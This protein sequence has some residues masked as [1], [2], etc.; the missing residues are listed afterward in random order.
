MLLKNLIKNLKQAKIVGNPDVDI[1]DIVINSKKT[2]KS[3]L[4]F[5][6]KGR[7][8]NGT[9]FVK[10]AISGGAVAIVTEKEI[11][12][13][14][15]QI[16]VQDCRKALSVVCSNFY[17]NPE[18]KMK[19]IAIIGTNG[20]TTT[21]HYVY[22]ILKNADYKV[23]L[24]GTLGVK[25]LDKYIE[26]DLT[27]P[28]PC[29]FYYL[30]SKMACEGITHLVMELSAHAIYYDKTFGIKYE[31]CV[32]TNLSQDHL[33]FFNT[34]EEYKR[35]KLKFFEEYYCK[36]KVVNN[37]DEV[38]L[39]ICNRH[40]AIS[41]GINNPADVFAIR[42]KQK[43]D[44]STFVINLFDC[45]YDVKLK[46]IGIHNVYNALGASTVCALLGVK[47]Y[48]IVEGLRKIESVDGRLENVYSNKF[49]VF[50]DYAHTPDGLEKSLTVLKPLCKKRLICVF[51]CGGN[52][53]STKRT[54]MGGISGKLADFTIVTTDNPRYEE[55]MSI[56]NQIEEGLIKEKGEYILIQD[57]KQAIKYALDIVND[58]D[59]VLIA[60]KGGEKYQEVLGVKKL[61]EDKKFVKDY[62]E[63]TFWDIYW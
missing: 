20:K 43:A 40:K 51:G 31:A 25:Y 22:S 55:P 11:G 5:C 45:V 37:D 34:M 32:F 38:G 14:I 17:H 1:K 13:P 54:I 16:I 30:L 24:M 42:V 26:S 49:N 63:C 8:F 59:I 60:G 21:A 10:E 15:T 19:I 62:L 47:T 53:D 6:L 57:R 28:D 46:M 52:R 2:T 41:Y 50:I 9:D 36:Y 33:D 29:K 44:Y 4:F 7:D 61:F 35:A 39:E 3:C 58:G 18:K 12:L 27:T 48:Q 56:I 23:G